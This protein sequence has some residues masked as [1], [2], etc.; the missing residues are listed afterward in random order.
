MNIRVNGNGKDR[1]LGCLK[2]CFYGEN[3]ETELIGSDSN[4]NEHKS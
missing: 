2:E 1:T 3:I 4:S